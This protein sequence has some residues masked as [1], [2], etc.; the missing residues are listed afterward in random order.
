MV[1][2]GIPTS[3]PVYEYIIVNHLDVY[4]ENSFTYVSPS[5]SYFRDGIIR[6]DAA[7][8]EYHDLWG[9]KEVYNNICTRHVA[10]YF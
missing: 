9:N 6:H 1:H 2:L 5:P 8:L 3:L 10:M 7:L 4:F